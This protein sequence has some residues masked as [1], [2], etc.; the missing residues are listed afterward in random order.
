MNQVIK[1]IGAA[2]LVAIFL[3]VNILPSVGAFAAD[4][5]KGTITINDAVSEKSY[6]IYKIFDLTY[7]GDNVSYTIAK[8][9]D[10]FFNDKGKAYIVDQNSGSLNPIIVNGQ[11]KYINITTDNVAEFANVAFDY[12]AKNIQVTKTVAA[13]KDQTTATATGLDLG[14]YLVNAKGATDV[15][16][17]QKSIV[18]LT[19][20][21]PNGKVEVK[22][23][24]P[25]I[26]KKAD[27]ETADFGDPITYTL[28]GQV[29]DTTGYSQYTYKITD[30]LGDGL[31]FLDVDQV[32]V[33][34]DETP[35]TEYVTK[36]IEGQT[37]TVDF[38]MLK[39]QDKV[40][41]TVEVTYKAKLNE[42]A[43]IGKGGNDNKVS[44]E[45]SNDPKDSKKIEKTPDKKVPVYTATLTINKYDGK[46]KTKATKLADAKFVLKNKEGKFYKYNEATKAVSWV[47]DKETPTVVNTTLQGK[48]QFKGLASGDY[49]LIETEAPKG[50]NLLTKPV[51]VKVDAKNWENEASCRANVENNSGSELPFVGGMGTIAFIIIGGG[52]G[53]LA[54]GLYRRNRQVEGN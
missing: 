7:K 28:T 38:D 41:K 25:T 45:Y 19:S 31:T 36:T 53:L 24:Y 16:K 3:A 34:V 33:K 18:S 40:G 22:A 35:I 4:A 10:G 2:L 50:Y 46:D 5:E 14:Y 20:T 6:D 29:P 52:I 43:V 49:Q 23:T 9:W 42:N 32:V 44:L 1:K 48:A 15:K 51:D 11:V 37:L 21:K 39:L 54:A 27:K 17:E 30:T 8:D 47:T 26:K 12:A 13:P